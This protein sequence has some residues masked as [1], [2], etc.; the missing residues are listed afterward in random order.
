MFDIIDDVISF[1]TELVSIFANLS[2]SL[3]QAT[4]YLDDVDFS[5]SFVA[6]YLGYARYTMGD[7]A[8]PMLM[9]MC[10]IGVAYSL[11]EFAVKG[12]T[13]MRNLLP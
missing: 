8:Y 10:L 1:F 2:E 4:V 12:V 9:T 6:K 7:P 5:Q 3:G 11:W 13:F